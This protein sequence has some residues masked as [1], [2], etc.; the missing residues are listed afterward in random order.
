MTYE[1]ARNLIKR[2]MPKGNNAM[3]IQLRGALDLA[4]SSL[5]AIEQFR[6]ERDVAI[7]QLEELGLSLGQKVDHIKELIEKDIKRKS[8]DIGDMV[9]DNIGIDMH[10]VVMDE[11]SDEE[12]YVFTDNGCIEKWDRKHLVKTGKSI[13]VETFRKLVETN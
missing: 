6:W 1:E 7:S 9:N 4:I 13:D 10:G 11:I 2:I 8:I 12:V 3:D 5:G